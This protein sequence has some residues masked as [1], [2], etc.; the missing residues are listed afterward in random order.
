MKDSNAWR[1]FSLLLLALWV[2]GKPQ[3][4]NASGLEATKEKVMNHLLKP[5]KQQSCPHIHLTQ[6][7][8]FSF[9]FSIRTVR[10]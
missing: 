2:E 4:K 1:V 6:W 9:N 8:T 7:D 3:Q 10:Q 5:Q